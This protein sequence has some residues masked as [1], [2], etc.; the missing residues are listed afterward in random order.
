MLYMSAGFSVVFAF[1]IAALLED[2]WM[3]GTLE[4]SV[5]NHRLGL[6]TIGIGLGSWWAYYE[7]SLNDWWFWDS[8]KCL[9]YA[10]AG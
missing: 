5:D 1:A 7:L 8:G 6:L 3:L 10:A 2:G 4:P 9:L